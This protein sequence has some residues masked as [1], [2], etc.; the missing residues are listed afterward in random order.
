MCW[1]SM[2]IQ[3]NST[4]FYVKPKDTGNLNI[5]D[6]WASPKATCIGSI[7]EP[8]FIADWPI[9]FWRKVK[10]GSDMPQC[11]GKDQE[12]RRDEWSLWH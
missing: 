6:P 2:T 8:I 9:P 5:C 11:V 4:G 7:L 10:L 3:R 12:Q 1:N